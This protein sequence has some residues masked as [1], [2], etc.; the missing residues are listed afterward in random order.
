MKQYLYNLFLSLSQ[1]LSTILGGDPD[2]SLSGRLG[3]AYLSGQPRWFVT[4]ALRLNDFLF[5]FLFKEQNHSINSVEWEEKPHEKEL[6]SWIKRPKQS[7]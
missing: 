2:E 6:W 5:K 7:Q 4:P 3:R 1:L